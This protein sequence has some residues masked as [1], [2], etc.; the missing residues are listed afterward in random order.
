MK[1]FGTALALVL[2]IEGVLYALFPEGMKRMAGQMLA[3]PPATLRVAG[4]ASAGLGV[5][6][7]WILRR[8]L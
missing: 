7:V 8:A 4:L 5:L 1:D 2:V 3:L 6:V